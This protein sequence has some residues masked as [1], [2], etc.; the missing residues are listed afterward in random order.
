[1]FSSESINLKQWPELI[2]G[3]CNKSD[4]Q[5][6][7]HGGLFYFL[8][9]Y[10]HW[11]IVMQVLKAGG[12]FGKNGKGYTLKWVKDAS[13]V[14]GQKYTLTKIKLNEPWNST[15]IGLH[16]KCLVKSAKHRRWGNYLFTEQG[17]LVECMG[18]PGLKIRHCMLLPSPGISLRILAS[19]E[20]TRASFK[21]LTVAFLT[22]WP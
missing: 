18:N 10:E 22:K 12:H 3:L 15:F 17:C 16:W 11:V 14:C 4:Q 20:L 6:M 21:N 19:Y 7:S 2:T 1:M 13:S 5:S 9:I 8:D